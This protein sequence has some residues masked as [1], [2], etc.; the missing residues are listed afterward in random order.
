MSYILRPNQQKAVND[1]LEFIHNEPGRNGIVVA[2]VAFG[3]SLVVANLARELGG[4]TLCLQPSKELLEQNYDKYTSYGEGA[5]IFSASKGIKEVGDVTFATAQS[6]A[7]SPN[8][9]KDFKYVT[10]D[11]CHLRTKVSGTMHKALKIINPKKVIGLTASPVYLSGGLD[12]SM[13]KMMNRSNKS[14]F[15]KIIHATQIHEMVEQG[16]WAPLVYQ[17]RYVDTNMLKYNTSQSDYTLESLMKMYEDNNTQSNIVDEVSHLKL[18]NRRSTLVFVPSI[19]E[20]EALTALIP[21]SAAVSSKTPPKLR[22]EIINGFKDRDI[23]TVFNVDILSVGFD[24]P[25]LDSIIT[26]RATASMAIYYQQCLDLDTEVLT[27]QGFKKVGDIQIGDKLYGYDYQS[28]KVVDNTVTDNVLRDSYKGEKSIAYTSN[29]IDF[30]VSSQ[31]E[32]IWRGRKA[33]QYKKTKACDML[34]NRGGMSVPISGIE[35]TPDSGLSPAELEFLGWFLSDG[36]LTKNAVQIAQSSTSPYLPQLKKCLD[37]CG[38]RYGEYKVKRSDPKY[39]DG[40][41]F[42]VSKTTNDKTK[43]GW[44]DLSK[45][46]NK[47]A[48]LQ[49]YNSLSKKDLKH[50]LK[51]LLL[52]DGCNKTITEYTVRTHLLHCGGDVGYADNLQSLF[53]RRGYSCVQSVKTPKPSSWNSNPAPEVFLRIKEG[54]TAF[55]SGSNTKDGSVSGKKPYTRARLVVDDTPI[56]YWCVTTTQGNII[57]RRNGKILITG[58]CG[59]GTRINE[60]KKDC[61]IVDLSGNSVKFG[62]VE[63]LTFEDVEGYG[64]GMFAGDRLLSGIPISDGLTVTKQELIDRNKVDKG[65]QGAEQKITFGKYKGETFGRLWVKDPNYLVWISSDK[66][67]P[68]APSGKEIKKNVCEFLKSKYL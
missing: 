22:K 37:E 36:N 5:S 48:P 35:V 63:T 18:D 39:N 10:I 14:F 50:L 52:G 33:A 23:H 26:A 8:L 34:D 9:F 17:N 29:K 67:E 11:E 44:A 42:V 43:R 65:G 58:N 3:K 7:N 20:A 15:K 46:I 68:Y 32:M 16:Y 12:G 21:N 66:F 55:V 51:G 49:V 54:T 30:K 25:L 62:K 27:Y 41:L 13:L 60:H 1:S 31:H 47:K 28:Q 19:E 64:W 45:Y 59:R 56:K 57:T 61:K 24:H 38:F 6:V 4:S 53:I 40:L 2:P